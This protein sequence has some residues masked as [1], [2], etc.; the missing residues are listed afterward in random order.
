[1]QEPQQE[2]KRLG[3]PAGQTWKFGAGQGATGVQRTTD[4]TTSYACDSTRPNHVIGFWKS[5]TIIAGTDPRQ[6]GRTNKCR[7]AGSCL[8][9]LVGCHERGLTQALS[10]VHSQSDPRSYLE[11]LSSAF[12]D[13]SIQS[14]RVPFGSF[15]GQ[16]AR[17]KMESRVKTSRRLEAHNAGRPNPIHPFPPGRPLPTS[18]LLASPP[19]RF[20]VRSTTAS[21]SRTPPPRPIHH[22]A[23][24][25]LLV[26]VQAT[27]RAASPSAP[28]R[29]RP[30]LCCPAPHLVAASPSAPPR[31]RPA[32]RRPALHLVAAS[33]SSPPSSSPTPP[34]PG[35]KHHRPSQPLVSSPSLP[36][37]FLIGS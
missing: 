28:S 27:R 25:L 3:F 7:G 30:P 29:R 6:C 22:A 26:A 11:L 37:S 15:P 20:P 34:W 32:P 9:G 4:Q 10:L 18:R 35:T 24:A 2:A 21:R 12:V 17:V 13:V 14:V 23:A 31:R 33:T 19:R 36:F 16:P 5:K 8:G 1:M